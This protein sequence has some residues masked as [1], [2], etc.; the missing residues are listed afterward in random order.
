[1]DDPYVQQFL[2]LR[3]G[4]LKIIDLRQL[5]GVVQFP[6]FHLAMAVI[7]TYAVRGIRV[8]FPVLLA[9][10]ALVIAATPLVGGHHFSDLWGG[11]LVTLLVILLM[12]RLA[13]VKEA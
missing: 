11:A 4:H 10:N 2:A 1:M 13:S 9:W 3:D 7:L 12:R 5:Q 6:S 8:L